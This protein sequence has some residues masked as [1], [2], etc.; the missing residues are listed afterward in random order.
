[1]NT[2]GSCK[3]YEPPGSGWEG[4]FG[5]CELL[6]AAGRF[7]Y[8]DEGRAWLAEHEDDEEDPAEWALDPDAMWM[9]R[10]HPDLHAYTQDASSYS[11]ALRVTPEFGCIHH[12]EENP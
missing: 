5:Y 2:C 4:Q 8:S 11:S 7:R 3:H 10:L 1:V 6:P 9:R 12:A